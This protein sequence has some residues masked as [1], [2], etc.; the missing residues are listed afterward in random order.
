MASER[1]FKS[2]GHLLLAGTALIVTGAMPVRA[3]EPEKARI[4]R[5]EIDGKKVTRDRPIAECRDRV[6]YLLNS[7][8]SVARAVQPTLTVEE[9]ERQE[10][11]ER[12]REIREARLKQEARVDRNLMQLYPNEIAHRK[13]RDKA[14]A[15][16]QQSVKT[17][18]ARIATLKKDRE[19]LEL[20][21]QFY[22]PVGKPLPFALKTKI[23]A[24]EASQN[25]QKELVQ[26]QQ[27]EVARL[28]AAYDIEL[29]RLRKLWAGAPPGSLGPLPG[30]QPVEAAGASAPAPAI[31]AKTPAAPGKT[32]VK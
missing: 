16:F 6:Q 26:G 12:E 31:I 30:P 29:M 10:Q 7:D 22:D 8:G 11:A 1:G 15:D 9:R 21:R 18:E 2:L 5:C 32:T 14:L 13:A 24:N 25:A 17:I 4:Y 20:E 19:P 3:A 28:N 23:D 27:G